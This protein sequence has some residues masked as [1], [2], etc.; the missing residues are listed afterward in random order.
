M[1]IFKA[2]RVAIRSEIG[3][4][5]MYNRLASETS[6]A[7]ARSLFEYLIEYETIHQQFLEAE[8]RSLS[9]A[10]RSK[11]GKP[12]HWLKLLRDE[13][14][15]SAPVSEKTDSDLIEMQLSL[16]AAENIAKILK[17][18]NEELS[19]RQNRYEQEL[20]IAAEIQR[21]LLPQEFPQHIGLQISA[22]NTMARSVGGDYYD[23]VVNDHDQLA[24]VVADSMGKGMPAALLMTTVRAVWQSWSKA[25]TSSPGETLEIINRIVYPDMTATQAFVTMF[26][27]VYDTKTSTF[28]YSRAGHNPPVFRPAMG[29][30]CKK[31]EAG[32]VPIGMFPDPSF[33]TE[34][35][36]I[37]QGDVL[38]IYT[39]GIVEAVNKNNK[40]FGI[41][42][43]CDIVNENYIKD[44]EK[45][46][47]IIIAE[48][49][50]YTGGSTQND[51]IT[52][53]VLKKT[54]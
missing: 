10:E 16:L 25:N 36:N 28:H 22:L 24:L 7:E 9:I 23:L 8:R 14:G 2:L 19:S 51:D 29:S 31:L 45:I 47:N 5:K 17:D 6:D 3:A 49:D 48:V 44:A 12:S 38:V 54:E 4:Q 39:D 13:L 41:D 30:G 43:L 35:F 53:M 11:E 46:K 33:P 26:S 34:S 50:T 42:R 18:A 40:L 32:N 15:K 27:A 20:A 52:L 37:S 1:D 21:K